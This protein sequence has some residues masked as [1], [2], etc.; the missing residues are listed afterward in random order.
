MLVT[1]SEQPVARLES[2]LRASA[3]GL[4]TRMLLG[5][6][7]PVEDY[8]GAWSRQRRFY[9]DIA[10]IF[11]A[12]ALVLAALGVYGTMAYA[13]VQR[14]RELAVR[15]TL[16]AR[17]RQLAGLVLARGARLAAIGTCFGLLG[18]LALSRFLA[19]LLF[20]V[21]ERDPLTLAIVVITLASVTVVASL[22]PAIAAAR[23][24]PMTVLRNE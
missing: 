5:T 24:D 12:A 19:A 16:G 6:T 22:L 4:S 7:T 13:V 18:A 21:G 1:K 11:A 2:A 23:T 10:V 3:A 8:L 14:R 17:A 15:A 9:L 20:G